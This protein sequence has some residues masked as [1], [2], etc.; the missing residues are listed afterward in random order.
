M[1]VAWGYTFCV[2]DSQLMFLCFYPYT[3]VAVCL[4]LTTLHIPLM[5]VLPRYGKFA[6]QCGPR[7]SQSASGLLAHQPTVTVL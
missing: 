3:A 6:D 4:C 2:K 1:I 5:A 7:H